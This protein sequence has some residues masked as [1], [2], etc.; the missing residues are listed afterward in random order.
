MV[1][2]YQPRR[3]ETGREKLERDERR[4]QHQASEN[5]E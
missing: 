2:Q 1:S 3:T 4:R 5:N